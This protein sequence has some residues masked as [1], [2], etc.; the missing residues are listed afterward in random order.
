MK[1]IAKGVVALF[2]IGLAA[3]AFFVRRSLLIHNPTKSE[4]Y[5]NMVSLQRKLRA[6]DT[7]RLSSQDILQISRTDSDWVRLLWPAWASDR[8]GSRP[9]SWPAGPNELMKGAYLLVAASETASDLPAKCVLV[10]RSEL[11]GADGLR[12]ALDES[13]AI[14]WLY[15]SPRSDAWIEATYDSRGSPVRPK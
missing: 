11:V 1:P 5:S 3:S 15:K 14:Q 7:R 6:L 2:V 12:F 13:Y 4:R 10:E 9:T 8:I